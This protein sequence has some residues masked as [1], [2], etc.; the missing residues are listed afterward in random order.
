MIPS[1][2]RYCV[3]CGH[4]QL[5]GNLCEKCNVEHNGWSLYDF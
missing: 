5:E 2:E 4:F 3:I 1:I